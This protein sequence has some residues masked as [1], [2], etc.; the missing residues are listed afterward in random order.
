MDLNLDTL[1]WLDKRNVDETPRGKLVLGSQV[2]DWLVKAFLGEGLS[3]EVYRVVHFTNGTEAALKLLVEENDGLRERFLIEE[4]ALKQLSSG[5]EGL[6]GFY[7]SG[8]FEGRPYYI[9]EFLL[10]VELPLPRREIPSFMIGVALAVGQ[11]HAHGYVHRDLK[12]ANIMRRKDGSPVLIDLGLIKALDESSFLHPYRDVSLVNGKPIGVGT[13]GYAPPEQILQGK[14]SVSNDIYSLGKVARACFKG[15]PPH[16]WRVIIR[17]ATSSEADDRYPSAE[18]FAQAIAHRNLPYQLCFFGGLGFVALLACLFSLKS[19]NVLPAPSPAPP[20]METKTAL[21]KK[22][23]NESDDAYFARLLPLAQRG[24]VDALGLVAEAHFFGHGVAKNLQQA[25]DYYTAAAI[26]KNPNAQA[27]LGHCYFNGYGCVKDYNRA[28]Y[29]YTLAAEAGNLSAM[30]DLGY[31]HL[32]GLGVN[33]NQEKAIHWISQAARRGHAD[34]QRL[35]GECYLT[36]NG[37]PS[38]SAQAAK[39]LHQAADKGNKRAQTLL[40]AL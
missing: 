1:A 27:S 18:D 25:V 3:G 11:L 29:W 23:A 37:V 5:F 35:L 21:L 8:I 31:C 26:L 9:M 6:P 36:G 14:C 12:P 19:P 22:D 15:R 40:K 34:A 33:K 7:T 32:N 30:S 16:T 13:V 4:R 20:V 10:P 24:N 38:D 39:W 28:I 2:G 17:Q